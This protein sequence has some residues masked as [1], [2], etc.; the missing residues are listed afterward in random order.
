[1]FASTEKLRAQLETERAQAKV[2]R[3]KSQS[4]G[5]VTDYYLAW[6]RIAE[7]RR[8][9]ADGIRLALELIARTAREEAAHG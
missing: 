4:A 9:R 1:M 3:E 6:G 5:M 2:A 8:G 7:Y